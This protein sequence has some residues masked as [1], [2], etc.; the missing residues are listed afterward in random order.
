MGIAIPIKDDLALVEAC[1]AAW[2][3]NDLDAI[4]QKVSSG[5]VYQIHAPRDVLPFAGRHEGREQI[6]TCLET[7]KRDL[8]FLAFAVD[9]VNGGEGTVR[10]RIIFYYK[11]PETNSQLDGCMRHV[12]RIENGK[13]VHVDEFHDVARLRAFLKMVRSLLR[14]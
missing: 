1:Y 8:D 13:V 2:A 10:A 12:W 14:R 3:A 9:W 7:I 11:D 4:V 5:A 6:R